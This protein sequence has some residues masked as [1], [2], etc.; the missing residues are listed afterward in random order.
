MGKDLL[1][2]VE[3]NDFM[4][5]KVL[6]YGMVGGGQ[7]AFIGDSHRKAINLDGQSIL[8][9][10]CFSRD[11]EN[12]LKTGMQLR[13]SPDRCYKTFEEMAKKE[14]EREDGID[15]VVIVTPN[16]THYPVSKAFLEAGIHVVCDKPLCLTPQQADELVALSKKKGLLFMV[17]YTY[18]GNVTAKYARELIKAGEL[19]KIRTIMG[20][21]PQAWLAYEGEWGGKQG[22]WR[23]DPVHSGGTNC[24]GDL[25]THIENTVS[26]ITGLKVKRVLAKMEV[27]VPG[28]VLDDND[29]V[30]VEY[31][32]GAS[33]MY[34]T[35][36]IAIGG[37]NPLRIRIY[38]ENGSIEWAQEEPDKIRVIKKDGTITEQ[39]RGYAAI[40]P[41]AAK[42]SRLPSGH[43]EG[44]F[45]ALAN[46]YR[47]FHECVFA[48]KAGV[49]EPEMIDFPTVEEG[50]E[51]I[52]FIHAC[53]ESQKKGNVWVDVK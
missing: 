50:A 5:G 52:H 28:R 11:H 12:C 13:V 23:T 21:Y 45:E 22:A 47:S 35:S 46:L 9:A 43:P 42:Y 17:T 1:L 48:K 24:L 32:N 4:E 36:Q 53:I 20:E 3:G 25:G 27:V 49:F 15:Y 38:G 18:I 39:H 10:G 8:V 7:G 37:D 6:H 26:A 34:W 40:L 31:D 33:G 14:A 2:T 41:A 44:W 30:M 16:D 29:F 51:G 19:G